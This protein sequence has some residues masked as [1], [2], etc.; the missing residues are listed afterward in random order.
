[1]VMAP[2]GQPL[3]AWRTFSRS[4]SPGCSFEHVE[5]A[6]VTHLEDLGGDAHAHGVAGALVVVHNNLHAMPPAARRTGPTVPGPAG[7]VG[8]PRAVPHLGEV[9]SSEGVIDRVDE[10]DAGAGPPADQGFSLP[11][12]HMEKNCEPPP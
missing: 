4:S 9:P 8:P 12:T 11:T 7:P 10:V 6:V 5:E 2:V 3:A 1:M